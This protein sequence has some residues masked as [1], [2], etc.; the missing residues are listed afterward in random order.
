MGALQWCGAV[1]FTRAL[2]QFVIDAGASLAAEN[3]SGDSA[4]HAAAEN[5][6]ALAVEA[7][8]GAGADVKKLNT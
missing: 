3:K 8:V 5:G 1:G 2:L 4:L 7:L 6:D